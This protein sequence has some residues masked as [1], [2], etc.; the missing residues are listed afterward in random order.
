MLA[1]RCPRTAGKRFLE[2]IL[3]SQRGNRRELGEEGIGGKRRGISIRKLILVF[4][5]SVPHTSPR[6]V[7]FILS[8]HAPSLFIVIFPETVGYSVLSRGEEAISSLRE[9][10]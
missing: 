2:N 1:A 8:L 7:F 10:Q 9:N 3:A 4:S 5:V 6:L